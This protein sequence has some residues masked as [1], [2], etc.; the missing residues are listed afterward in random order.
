V[1][2]GVGTIVLD[3]RRGDGPPGCFDYTMPVLA[4]ADRL[5]ECSPEAAAAALRALV[6][7]Q[8]ALKA[9]VSRATEVGHKRFPPREAGLIAGIVKR[10]LPF[11]DAMISE[12]SLASI[13]AFARRIGVLDDDVAYSDIVATRF[14]DLWRPRM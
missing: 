8:Q 11:Y 2:S 1:T 13:N 10:D 6:A 3:V 14:C 5:I 12:Q 7:A 9:D 4:V